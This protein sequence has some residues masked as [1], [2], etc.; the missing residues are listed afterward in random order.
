MIWQKRD[1]F[2][3][4][5]SSVL[6]LSLV[7]LCAVGYILSIQIRVPAVMI[8][9]MVMFVIACLIYLGSFSILNEIPIPILLIILI[10]PIPLQ[11][12]TVI[13]GVLQLWVSETATFLIRVLSIP[14]YREGNVLIIVER[15][16]QVVDAC[17]GVRSLI[18]L[19]TLSLILGYFSFTRKISF[20]LLFIVSIPVALFV[21]VLRVVS[22]VALYHFFKVDITTG[23]PHTIAGLLLFG[24]GLLV[25]LIFQRVFEEWE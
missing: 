4:Y 11:L 7:M 20:L 17:S 13:T 5:S 10:I 18:S 12:M 2:G 9:T 23:A 22:M 3:K 14:I 1:V 6:G 24:I 19:T 8:L 25:L 21:N 15:S 16:F